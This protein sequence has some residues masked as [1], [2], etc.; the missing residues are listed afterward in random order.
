[1]CSISVCIETLFEAIELARK[2]DVYTY[3]GVS[4]YRFAGTTN[5]KKKEFYFT[6]IKGEI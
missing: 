2:C 3:M 1:M 5:G 6:C 4:F